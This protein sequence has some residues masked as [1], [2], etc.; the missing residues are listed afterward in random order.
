[1]ASL[2]A[3]QTPLGMPAATFAEYEAA[4][5]AITKSG[6]APSDVA[7][8][9]VFTTDAP[10]VQMTKVVTDIL[11]QP[12]PAP[13]KPFTKTDDFADYCVYATTI[14]MPDYQGG[15]PPFTSTGGA[16]TFDASGNPVVQRHEEANLFVTIPRTAMPQAGYPTVV[17][18]NTGAG[19]SRPIVDRGT[20]PAT[21]SAAVTPGTGPAME[22]ARVGYAGIQVDGP[23]DGLRNTTDGNEDFLIFNV[24]NPPAL[25]DSVRESAV[26]AS[27][28]SR[29]SWTT[30]RSTRATARA[31]GEPRL[32]PTHLAI[33]GH[34]MGASILPSRWRSSR[35][36]HA[37]ILSG[38]GS[39]WI[40]NVMYKEQPLDVLNALTLLTNYEALGLTLTDHDPVLTL[41]QWAAEA[42]DSQILRAAPAPR[43]ARRVHPP[44]LLMVQGIVDH[45]IMPPIANAFTASTGLDL[46]GPELDTATPEIASLIPISATFPI[47]G[48]SAIAYPAT[49]NVDGKTTAVVLQ[50]PSDGVEDGHEVLFQTEPPKYQYKCFLASL[51]TGTPVVLDGTGK[52]DDSP[53]P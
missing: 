26:E 49:A 46:V 48:R 37:A 52:T 38:C 34:S 17:F 3:N 5:A 12:R 1:M 30:S 11:A 31:R 29:T 41:F 6:V 15:T 47:S 39:S 53:C 10:F 23:L 7:A 40:D 18:I 21:G 33:M 42:A 4:L 36:L 51:L 35:A 44:H 22:F 24:F 43:A 45:Y 25:R 19:G 32:D 16:W 50:A 8:L 28:S 20:Q 13:D 27:S 9:S 14:H 2:L